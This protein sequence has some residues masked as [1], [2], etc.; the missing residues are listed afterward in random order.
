MRL[1]GYIRLRNT[2]R[3]VTDEIKARRSATDP[4]RTWRQWLRRPGT[5]RARAVC[6]LMSWGPG[7]RLSEHT[8]LLAQ[9]WAAAGFAVVLV[10]ARDDPTTF[11]T[12]Q[13]LDFCE[14]VLLRANRG[15]DFG[16]WATAI[17]ELPELIDA[18]LLAVAND[19][20][21][22]PLDG[23]AAMIDRARAHPAAL[24][25]AVRSAE[26]F[27]HLQS[28]LLFFKAAALRAPIFTRFWRQVR[29]G[30][31]D[32]AIR[33]YEL[34][35]ERSFARAGVLTG[36]LFN[37]EDAPAVNPTLGGWRTLL[38]GQFPFVKLQ[39]LRDAPAGVDITGWEA[40][41]ASRGFD[42]DVAHRY[43]AA[44]PPR[45]PALP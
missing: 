25:G 43:L 4:L 18:E 1:P 20:V 15:Y 14:G 39:L 45:P 41:L 28:F 29:D 26:L 21:L 3:I 23:F 7:P 13:D 44:N 35:L 16:A 37:V 33:R 42:P 12:T 6:V 27:P 9:G 5:L 24:V 36:A 38:E 31:R 17:R 22:G 32:W 11:D 19:S 30:D 40:L 2:V 10:V 8:R 34:R